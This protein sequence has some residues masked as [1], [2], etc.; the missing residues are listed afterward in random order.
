MRLWAGR[1]GKPLDDSVDHLNRSLPYDIRLA[2]EDIDV[3]KAWATALVGA[4]V[5]SNEEGRALRKALEE[6]REIFEQGKF[7]PLPTDEDIHTA[8]ERLL[9]ETVGTLGEKIHTGRSRNDQVATGFRLWVMRACERIREAIEAYAEAVLERA[10]GEIETLMPGYTHLQ[11]AQP[12]TWSHWLLAHFW[13]IMRDRERFQRTEAAAGWMPL[14]SGALAGTPYDIDL[15]TLARELGFAEISYNSIDAVS[16]RDFLLEFL[17]AASTLG[18]HLS[19]FGEMLILFSTSEFGFIELD[20]A[21]VTGSSLMPQ[22]KNPDV[23]ELA[24]GKSGRLIGNLTG[25]L[26]TLKGLP[27]AYDKDLQEDKEPVFDSFDTLM[28]ILPAMTGLVGSMIIQPDRMRAAIKPA[29]LATDLADYLVLKGVTFREAHQVVG[30]VVREA[31]NRGMPISELPLEFLQQQHD[32]FDVD[33]KEVFDLESA[34]RRRAVIGGTAPK[35]VRDQI[36]RA[37]QLLSSGE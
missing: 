16:D 27:S 14:G 25:L 34:I 12:V 10:H 15:K 26:S 36:Q 21:F 23:L 4:G 9:V 28:A 30:R 7:E 24:R 19:R 35:S 32:A 13:A 33:V 20:E 6:V 8:V 18:V 31:E 1:I 29:S 11:H 37:T 5:L 22:K 3:S 2:Q 17:L